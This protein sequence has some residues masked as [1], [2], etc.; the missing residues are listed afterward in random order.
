MST[1]R[2]LQ[3]LAAGCGIA[4]LGCAGSA[5]DSSSADYQ[6]V[7]AR[8]RLEIAETPEIRVWDLDLGEPAPGANVFRAA[9]KN[10]PIPRKWVILVRVSWWI[11][12]V[13]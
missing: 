9:V 2:V 7:M 11:R 1:L 6:S 10:L 3:R 5:D 13:F 12:G 8:A 4:A